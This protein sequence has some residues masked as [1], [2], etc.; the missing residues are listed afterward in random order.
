M[1]EIILPMQYFY[2]PQRPIDEF[3]AYVIATG[4]QLVCVAS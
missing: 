3:P 1:L 4:E 2:D